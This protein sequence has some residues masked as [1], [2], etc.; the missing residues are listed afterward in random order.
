MVVEEEIERASGASFGSM[1]VDDG[2]SEAGASVIA[3][4]TLDIFDWKIVWAVVVLGAF[5]VTS[6]F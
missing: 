5:S 3:L 6:N 1:L 2:K 4:S